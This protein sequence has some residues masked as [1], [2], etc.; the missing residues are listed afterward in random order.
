MKFC[1]WS[2]RCLALIKMARMLF[3]VVLCHFFHLI[4]SRQ[5]NCGSSSFYWLLT[6]SGA[7]YLTK[8]ARIDQKSLNLMIFEQYSLP[9]L[10]FDN[11]FENLTIP[12]NYQTI[13]RG[14]VN[15]NPRISPLL[16]A[17]FRS[18]FKKLSFLLFLMPYTTS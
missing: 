7:P 3:V 11:L 15:I 4:S 2:K 6:Q 16:L 8:N 12:M 1:A 14:I 10:E 5:L 18:F 13:E 17:N 9:L